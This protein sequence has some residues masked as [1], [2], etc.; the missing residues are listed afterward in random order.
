MGITADILDQ[1]AEAE[2]CDPLELPPLYDSID[3]DALERCVA[4]A[5]APVTFRFTYCSH[6]VTVRGHDGARVKV[7]RSD[8][9]RD[10]DP[11]R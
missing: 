9:S 1:V 2:G 4:S 6:T 11:V 3:A 7:D 10:V 8:G 5:D